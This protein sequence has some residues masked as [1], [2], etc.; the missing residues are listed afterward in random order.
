MKVCST[1]GCPTLIPGARRRCAPHEREQEQARGSRQARGYGAEHDRL[2]AEWAPQVAT[3]AV[4]CARCHQPIAPDTA[5]ELDHTD[6]RTG[7][8]GPSCALCNRSA[9]GRA[10]HARPETPGGEPQRGV[11][12]RYRRGGGSQG[13]TPETHLYARG[14]GSHG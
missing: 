5:W 9:G 4:A 14:G 3:G 13:A 2:R 6:D 11:T 1:T 12:G 8:L 7:Y 10:A